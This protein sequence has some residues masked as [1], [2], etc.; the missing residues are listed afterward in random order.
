MFFDDRDGKLNMSKGFINH[1]TSPANREL[2]FGPALFSIFLNILFGANAVAVKIS[3]SGLGVFTTAGLR[4]LIAAIAISLWAALTGQSLAINR[5]QASQLIILSLLFVSQIALFYL[6]L[7]LTTAS[8]GV[9]IGNLLPFVVLLLAHFYIPGDRITGRKVAGIALGFCGVL[10]VV[11]DRQGASADI[12]YGDMIIF[13]AVMI[14]GTSAVF[15]KKISTSIHPII[16]SLYPMFLAVPLFLLTGLL[17]DD[18]MVRFIDREVVLSLLYQA[19]VTA[20]FG[21]IAWNTLI[22]KYGATAL[23]SFVFIMPISGVFFGVILLGE[24]LTSHLLA[25]IFL[26]AA[27]IVVIN[28]R[29]RTASISS[30]RD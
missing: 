4:F 26:I 14:W 3:L 7:N 15:A 6:G 10:F 17:W 18:D 9:L 23:H 22:R 19:L 28:G 13:C 5:Q 27:G 20:S 1:Q 8:H 29:R 25:A 11:L 21:F 2:P 30:E 24:P 12:R 16:I